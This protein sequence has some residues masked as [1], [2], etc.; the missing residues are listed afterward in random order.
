MGTVFGRRCRAAAANCRLSALTTASSSSSAWSSMGD[1][2]KLTKTYWR[3]AR[4]RPG[5]HGAF[6]MAPRTRS[7]PTSSCSVL[8]QHSNIKGH[9]TSCP[10]TLNLPSSKSSSSVKQLASHT[11]PTSEKPS[12]TIIII[13]TTKY[14]PLPVFP[15]PPSESPEPSDDT[16]L[17]GALLDPSRAIMEQSRLSPVL[18]S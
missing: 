1:A 8:M 6:R 11:I 4:R 10:T 9:L 3:K 7:R 14:H 15:P 18:P 16:V 13:I 2:L 17:D 5:P 12:L